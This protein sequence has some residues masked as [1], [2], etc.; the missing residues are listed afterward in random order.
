MKNR[1]ITLLMICALTNY[2]SILHAQPLRKL[3][4]ALTDKK[5][6]WGINKIPGQNTTAPMVLFH[7]PTINEDT[8][9]VKSCIRN[10]VSPIKEI[11]RDVFKSVSGSNSLLPYQ[12][13]IESES[14][15][16]AE[17]AKNAAFVYFMDIDTTGN[18][19]DPTKRASLRH[20]ALNMLYFCNARRGKDKFGAGTGDWEDL[21]QHIAEDIIN[22]CIR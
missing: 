5:G 15:Q 16:G 1:V 14:D 20:E 10:S 8:A 19:L 6:G 22:M 7:R 17:W 3:W 13:N 21:Q 2:Y 11:Y 12:G 9:F 4:H 18:Q